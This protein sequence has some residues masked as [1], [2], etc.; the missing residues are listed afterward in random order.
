M[1]SLFTASVI[2][3]SMMLFANGVWAHASY[4]G[5][6]GAPGRQACSISCHHTRDFAPTVAVTGFPQSYVPGQQYSIAVAHN[7][8]TTIK[9]FNC[10]IRVGTGSTNA[11]TIVSSTGT[12]TYNTTGETNGVH[13]SAADQNSATFLWTAPASGTGPVRLYWAGLQG[14][15]STGADTQI[16]LI[17]TEVTSGVDDNTA[18]PNNM[19]LAQNYP[20]PFNA[21][22]IIKFNLAQPGYVELSICNLLGQEIYNWSSDFDKAGSVSV[23]W[24]GKNNSGFDMPSGVYFYQLRTSDGKLTRQMTL[25]R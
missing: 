23:L 7:G 1:K 11:G 14:T 13:F 18:L 19:S 17:S 22:T 5:Y 10:S 24:N 25:L 8:G 15:Y 12:S 9:Q 21:E 4:T 3:V 6:S 20:N 2:L 16:V